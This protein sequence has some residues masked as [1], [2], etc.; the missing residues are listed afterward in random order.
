M[1]I[2]LLDGYTL[3]PG[4]LNWAPLQEIGDFTVYDRVKPDEIVEKAKEADILLTNK[5]KLTAEI[6]EQ[7]PNVKYIGVTATGYNIVDTEAAR[8]RNIPV[9]N[10][11]EYSS[12]AVAQ[13]TFS[14]ILHFTN[15]VARLN[16]SVRQKQWAKS[17]DF[18]YS[19]SPL[20]ELSGKTL[21]LIG[22]GSIAKEV[23]KIAHAFG[24]R[25]IAHR[26][27]EKPATGFEF[28][29]I[30]PLETVFRESDVVSLH[31][32]L[33]EETKGII[34][35]ERLGWMKP[36]SYLIN[37]GRG[38][39]IVEQDLADALNQGVIAGAG[40]DVLSVEPPSLDNPLPEAKNCVITPHVAWLAFE[41]R[42]RLLQMTAD[43]I[44][45]F[46][47]GTPINVVN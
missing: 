12:R 29:E 34:N 32:P 26:R 42:R 46:L 28:V 39:L 18:C 35:A 25:V 8:K 38:P 21:G 40:L 44:K 14:L 13:H 27:S 1:K 20:T 30:L 31:C 43:N 37:T 16:E 4:D 19:F 17:P 23:A 22:F 11:S 24:M 15:D 5:S 36:T 2:V 10:V 33:T 6:L 3:N 7:L 45:A 41:A 47:N 9:T